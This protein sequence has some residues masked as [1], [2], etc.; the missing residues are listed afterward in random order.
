M[1][2][3]LKESEIG[4]VALAVINDTGQVFQRVFDHHAGFDRGAAGYGQQDRAFRLK[5]GAANFLSQY[6]RMRRVKVIGF[7][8]ATDQHADARLRQAF[9]PVAPGLV[10]IGELG[11]FYTVGRTD[12]RQGIGVLDMI[13]FRRDDEIEGL[14][15]M[16]RVLKLDNEG[17]PFGAAAHTAAVGNRS[18]AGGDPDIGPRG[19]DRITA[20]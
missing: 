4:I 7:G 20:A 12:D 1:I 13:M 5:N 11:G 9:Q 19:F 2:G 10:G 14:Q 17:L 15:I 8:A 18:A 3:G 16:A 6:L